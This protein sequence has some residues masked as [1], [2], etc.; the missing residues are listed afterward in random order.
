MRDIRQKR[1]GARLIVSRRVPAAALLFVCAGVMA[2]HAD[3]FPHRI[4]K[5]RTKQSLNSSWKFIKS[6][7]ASAQ[8]VAFDDA[9]WATVNVPHSAQYDPPT[10]AGELNSVPTSLTWNGVHWYR[11]TFTVPSTAHNQ[12]VF[13]Q[14]DGA[15]QIAQVYLNGTLLGTHDACGFTGFSFD[16]SSPVIRSGTNVLAVRLDCR[17]RNNIPPGRAGNFNATGTNAEYPDFLIYSGLYRDVWLVCAD[18]IYIPANG[19]KVSTPTATSSSATVRVRTSVTN[20][21]AAA[22]NVTV[23]F[24][25]VNSG[26][27]IL[28]TYGQTK[29]MAAGAT[30]VFDTTSASL[31]GPSLWSP[32]SPNLYRIFTKVSTDGADVDDY[33]ERFGIRSISW[34]RAGGFYLNGARTELKGVCMHQEF[35]WVE[36]AVPHSRFFEEVRLAKEMGANSIRCSHYPRAPAFYNACDELGVICQVELPSWGCCGTA[37]YPTDFWTRMNT[38]AQ[39]MVAVGYNHPSIILWGMFNEPSVN[40]NLQP[41]LTALNTVVKGLDSTRTSTVYAASTQIHYLCADVYGMNYELYPYTTLRTQ[42]TGSFVSEYYEGWIKW[43][44]RGDTSRAND[45]ALSGKLSENRYASDHWSGSN[46]WTAIDNAWNGTTQPVPGGGYMWCFIDYISPFQNYPMGV[47]DIYRIPKKAFY[48][49][50]TNWMGTAPDTFVVG[51]TP[52]RVQL[53]ADLTTITADSTDITRIIASLRDA[54]GRCAF[55]ARSVTLALTGPADCFDTLTRTTIA[56]KIGWVLKSRTTTGTIRA[57]VTS[58]GLPPDTV[59]INS[60]AQDN[61]ALPF[62]W[63]PTS[64]AYGGFTAAGADH[65]IHVRQNGRFIAVAFA[66]PCA[67]GTQVSLLNVLGR[68]A[69]GPVDAAGR[70]AVTIDAKNLPAGCYC[71][72]AGG[73]FAGKVMVAARPQ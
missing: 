36:N 23:T 20:A 1:R 21:N 52:A 56:G 51:I 33:A 11:K 47:L 27:T 19:Q 63:P 58:S 5:I 22:K 16:I 9:A 26:G 41:Q 18:N 55:V 12:K 59:V 32:G 28:A 13:L 38:V 73:R 43:C 60:V 4:Y 69:A 44:Y 40:L 30:T 50:R 24:C 66:A 15:M 6:D 42:V 68:T 7:P 61:S 65:W 31:A 49:F 34:T 53:D 35:A 39:E 67:A 70:R 45:A 71:L 10:V 29:T 48:T 37:T 57:I 14:F 3:F 2:A 72:Y 17:Y 25:I 46:N 8:A 62:I 64:V 54:Q